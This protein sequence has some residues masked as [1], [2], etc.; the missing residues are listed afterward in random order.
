MNAV[1]IS[2]ATSLIEMKPM[3]LLYF[4]EMIKGRRLKK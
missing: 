2:S 3:G 1:T 4:K